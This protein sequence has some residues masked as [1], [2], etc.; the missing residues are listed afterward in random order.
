MSKSKKPA[1]GL[2]SNPDQIVVFSAPA[3]HDKLILDGIC[4]CNSVCRV[5]NAAVVDID[6]PAL[7]RPAGLPLGRNNPALL[8]EVQHRQTFALKPQSRYLAGRH[9][10]KDIGDFGRR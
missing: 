10:G 6:A 7:N 5:R 3:Q 4:R 1:L 8:Q 2:G 9:I